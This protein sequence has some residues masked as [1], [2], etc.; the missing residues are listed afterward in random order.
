MNVKSLFRQALVAMAISGLFFCQSANAAWTTDHTDIWWNPNESG[1]GINM[2]QTNKDMFVTFYVYGSDRKP[3]WFGGTLSY[4]GSHVFSG[5]L[6][7]TS[8]PFYGGPFNPSNVTVREAGSASVVFDTVTAAT[9]T[10]TV[11]GVQVTKAIERQPI[12]YDDYN[13]DYNVS[14]SITFTGCNNPSYNGTFDDVGRFIIT[15]NKATMSLELRDVLG[16]GT[17]TTSGTYSQKGRMGTYDGPYS[18]SW[19]ESGTAHFYEMTNIWYGL[20]ARLTFNSPNYGC[21]AD[22]EVVGIMPR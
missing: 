14:Y 7:V 3:T 19:G 10:Y 8:G 18:C 13:G 17:C 12:T 1:W 15:Q 11:D 4:Q 21:A 5:K 16:T 9:L 2:I 20:A 6:Y 22:G